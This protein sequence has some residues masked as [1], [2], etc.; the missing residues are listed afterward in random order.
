VGNGSKH[1]GAVGKSEAVSKMPE[2]VAVDARLP[3]STAPPD[4]PDNPTN[5]A[6]RLK[7]LEL[8]TNADTRYD[9]RGDF[10]EGFAVPQLTPR[11]KLFLVLC[12]I[13]IALLILIH[14][15]HIVLRVSLGV[16]VIYGI[17]YI[18]G[19]LVNHTV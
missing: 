17:H 18:L 14:P 4:D 3:P 19:K 15:Q 8:Q 12:G 16:A 2:L 5:V 13:V 6:K 11:R 9:P 10:R 1:A 7:A